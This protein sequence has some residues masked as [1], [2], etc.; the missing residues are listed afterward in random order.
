[1]TVLAVTQRP[2]CRNVYL[3][4]LPSVFSSTCPRASTFLHCRRLVRLGAN[5]THRSKLPSSELS[6][7]CQAHSHEPEFLNCWF[8]SLVV[9][10]GVQV[11]Y[12]GKCAVFKPR[13]PRFVLAEAAKL[14]GSQSYKPLVVW[15][16]CHC[17]VGVM[18]AV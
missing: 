11:R 13:D 15:L 8:L 18:N 17:A 7:T 4:P 6:A 12:Q 14:L 10:L 9:Y 1:M 3:L 2:E 16:L 5:G